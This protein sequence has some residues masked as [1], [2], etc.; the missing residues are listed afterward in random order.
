MFMAKSRM[1]GMAMCDDGQITGNVWVDIRVYLVYIKLMV[2]KSHIHANSPVD[3]EVPQILRDHPLTKW[4]NDKKWSWFDHQIKCLNAA[5]G[6]NDFVLFA[7]TGAGKTLS[8]FLPS[9]IDLHEYGSN[10][11]LHTLYISPLKALAVDV[12]RNIGKPIEDLDLPIRHETRTGDTPQSKRARQKKNPPDILM[13]TPESLALMTSYDNAHT[14]FKDLKYVVIDELHA[15]LHSKRADLLS[16]NLER[17]SQFAPNMQRIGLSATLDD[18]DT[19]QEWLCRKSG[20]II[21]APNVTKPDIEILQS[22]QRIPWSGHSAKYAV[23]QIYD[24]VKNA[25]MS[26]VFVNTRAQAEYMLQNL[27]DHN[28]DNLK[29]GIHHGSL[30]RELRRKIETHMAEGLV[31]C[32]VA[33]GSLDL[34]LDWANVDLVIQVGAPKGVSRLLQRIGRSNHRLDEPSRAILVPTN[35]FEYIECLAAISEIEKG[36]LDGIAPKTGGLDVL[37]QHVFGVACNG[38]FYSDDLYSEAKQAWPYRNLSRDDFDDVIGFVMN[39]GYALK[40]YDRF[41]RLVEDEHNKGH[42]ALKDE[43]MARQYRMNIGTIVEAPILKVMLRNKTLGSI[44]ENFVNNLTIGD[45]FLFGGQV[46]EFQ[47]IHNSIVKVT[48]SKGGQAQIPSYAGGRMPLSTHLS[49]VVRGMIGDPKN[50]TEFP[51]QINEWLTLQREKS[52]LPDTN[53]LLVETFPFEQKHY[54]VAYTFAGRNANETLGF[55]ILRRLKRLKARPMGF[56]ITDYALAVWALKPIENPDALFDPSIM[57]EDFEEWIE[58]T[59]LMKR[60]FRDA[61]VISGMIERRH[62]G[63]TKTGRQVLVSSDLI[64]DVLLKYEP[65]HVLLRAAYQDARHGLIDADR[66]KSFLTSIENN[67]VHRPLDKISP[68]A[69][70]TILQVSRETLA[71]KDRDEYIFED[72]EEQILREANVDTID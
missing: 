39:G 66:I 23:P 59:P 37:A 35:R 14:Y 71:R 5:Q 46:L 21:T 24:A 8:G 50:W 69:V 9:L 67:I 25:K 10:G 44:E 19:A 2:Q 55:L 41:A 64:Y 16:L 11:K 1:I 58:E 18:R 54:M 13:T 4:L 61:A 31:N 32:V 40:S 70:P 65:N 48:K 63:S 60:L 51:S 72:I 62:P 12:H 47:G 38:N 28:E 22:D 26:V 57:F 30:E 36:N 45:T 42:F 33:T 49:N 43:K 52:L 15:F 17:L 34:G 29:I 6:G 68:M 56:V 7:P 3:V 20:T 27:W 53:N